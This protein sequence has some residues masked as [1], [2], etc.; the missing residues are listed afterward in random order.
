L[1]RSKPLDLLVRLGRGGMASRRGGLSCDAG[2]LQVCE[3]EGSDSGGRVRRGGLKRDNSVVVEVDR[4][5]RHT[6]RNPGLHRREVGEPY[7]V[8]SPE[9]TLVNSPGRKP[10]GFGVSHESRKP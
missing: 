5:R 6:P 7:G 3:D 2:I 10:C 1:L 4:R 8:I 9:G